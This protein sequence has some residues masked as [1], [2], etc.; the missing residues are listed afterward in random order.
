MHT[1]MSAIIKGD[2]HAAALAAS[3]RGIP[4][5]FVREVS[6]C[7]VIRTG[8]AWRDALAAWFCEAPTVAPFPAGTC[9]LY[10]THTD[11]DGAL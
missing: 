7:T 4:A 2:K 8:L 3:A 6:G 1:Y 5:A 11:A 9:L 10:S